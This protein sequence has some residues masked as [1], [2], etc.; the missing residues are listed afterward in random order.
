MPGKRKT[1][2]TKEKS[3][4]K[5]L[6]NGKENENVPSAVYLIEWS[7]EGFID[8]FGDQAFED[9][10]GSEVTNAKDEYRSE[11][12]RNNCEGKSSVAYGTIEKA[13]DAAERK[14]KEL[15]ARISIM[16]EVE[17]EIAEDQ[18]Y[19]YEMKEGSESDGLKFWE[20]DIEDEDYEYGN[21][22]HY[23]GFVNIVTFQVV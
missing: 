4:R 23:Y 15:K 18:L 12:A 2:G 10:Y 17:E 14:F 22:R 7:H 3:V 5:K 11:V 6:K 16:T 19:S 8:K 13:N 21:L 9:C 1:Q 20:W